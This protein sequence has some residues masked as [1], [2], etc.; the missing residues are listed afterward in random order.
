[1]TRENQLTELQYAT[2]AKGG[3]FKLYVYDHGQYHSGG[4]WFVGNGRRIHY[5]D[6]EISTAAA[7]ALA[8][9]A[10]ERGQEVRIC[11][12]GDMLVYHSVDGK[13]LYPAPD[14][15]FWSQL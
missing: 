4:Q 5:A 15:S 9:A 3:V 14:V 8:E 11:D 1:M 2:P 12:G 6:E 13:Q 10:V 7:R